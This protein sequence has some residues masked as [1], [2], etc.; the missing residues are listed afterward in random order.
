[1]ALIESYLR[2]SYVIS[3]PV[4]IYSRYSLSLHVDNMVKF[5][6]QKYIV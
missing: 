6:I 4:K 5:E 2:N 1:V 3:F